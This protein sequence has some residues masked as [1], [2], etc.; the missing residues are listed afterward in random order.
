MIFA[1]LVVKPRVEIIY[2]SGSLKP[3]FDFKFES[4]VDIRQLRK[5]NLTHTNVIKSVE[6]ATKFC[7]YARLLGAVHAETDLPFEP[8]GELV[9]EFPA[10]RTAEELIEGT[11]NEACGG[12]LVLHHFIANTADS[13]RLA[14]RLQTLVIWLIECG[15]CIEVPDENWHVITLY[16]AAEV[17][18]RT[19]YCLVGF[20]TAYRYWAYDKFEKQIDK[21]R[22]RLSQCVVLPPF[23]RKGHASRLLRAVYHLAR[24]NEHILDV[25]VE[26]PSP[27]F[28]AMRDVADACML[29]AELNGGLAELLQ[30]MAALVNIG[31]RFKLCMRQLRRLADVAEFHKA[32]LTDPTV[33][34]ETCTLEALIVLRRRIK[35]RLYHECLIQQGRG[36]VE[37]HGH[38]QVN[39]VQQLSSN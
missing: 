3:W 10:P 26:D 5:E 2:A 37:N 6:N 13:V 12:R 11:G 38:E 9:G 33:D 4:K 34:P 35:K 14:L 8:V 28:Q 17:Q 32:G 24:G 1:F 19:V 7:D 39:V 23:Q 36:L 18:N 27:D 20:V 15:G 30:G 16:H 31:R 25:T 21:C 29:E 22:L